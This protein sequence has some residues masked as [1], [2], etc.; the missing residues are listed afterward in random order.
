VKPDPV[1]RAAVLAAGEVASLEPGPVTVRPLVARGGTSAQTIYTY[2][3]SIGG[4]RRAV[5]E[6]MCAAVTEW[7]DGQRVAFDTAPLEDDPEDLLVDT[8]CAWAEFVAAR[9]GPFVMLLRG[10]G[11]GVDRGPVVAVV[12]SVVGLVADQIKAAG[13]DPQSAGY[14]ATARVLLGVAG[15]HGLAVAAG[16]SEAVEVRDRGIFTR[17]LGLQR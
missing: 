8:L 5:T 3:G 9:P 17:V 7:V 4:A 16:W 14:E 12:G 13:L 10:A 6:F 2:F 11:P 15:G 1:K